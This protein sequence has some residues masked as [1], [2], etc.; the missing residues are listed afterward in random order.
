MFRK[1]WMFSPSIE[2]LIIGVVKGPHNKGVRSR[3][4]LFKVVPESF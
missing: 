3:G 1:H 2:I 4:K